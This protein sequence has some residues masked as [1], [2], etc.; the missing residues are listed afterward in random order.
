MPLR[1]TSTRRPQPPP[2]S[3]NIRHK[4]NS[5]HPAYTINSQLSMCHLDSSGKQ[6]NTWGQ[7][8]I[9]VT[10][11]RAHTTTKKQPD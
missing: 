2:K 3:T 8:S 1:K 11:L 9:A 5:Q 10:T 6:H 4:S 7:G